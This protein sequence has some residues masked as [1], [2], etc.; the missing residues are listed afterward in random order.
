M[1]TIVTRSGK[2]SALSWTEADANFTNLNTDKLEQADVEAIA[3]TKTSDTG[4]ANL[5]TGTELQRPT[6]VAG[7][8]RFNTDTD[9]FEGYDG[10][11]WGAVGGG[12]GATG[13]GTDE[14][15]QENGTTVTTDYTLTT[16]KNA[17]SVG[18][19]TV[20]GG[21]A[22]TVPSGQRWVVL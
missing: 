15:F 12:G 1:S 18:P 4:A 11:E 2:G 21:V 16:G 10:T 9:T 17:M 22:V 20:N 13:G 5:P 8:F 6:P 7:M 14:V 19:I 3:V